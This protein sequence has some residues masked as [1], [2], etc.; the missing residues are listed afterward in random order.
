MVLCVFYGVV[1]IMGWHRDKKLIGLATVERNLKL[2]WPTGYLTGCYHVS[3]ILLICS[4]TMV[5]YWWP[6]IEAT[7]TLIETVAG[8]LP[9]F[10]FFPSRRCCC[11]RLRCWWRRN[12][13][14]V[15][16]C[17]KFHWPEENPKRW[18][19]ANWCTPLQNPKNKTYA[20]FFFF[21]KKIPYPPY[22]LSHEKRKERWIGLC[23]RRCEWTSPWTRRRDGSV[24]DSECGASLA[25]NETVSS[26]RRLLRAAMAVTAVP[27]GALH[28][29][30]FGVFGSADRPDRFPQESHS[31]ESPAWN[32]RRRKRGNGWEM[33]VS[34][35]FEHVVWICS[36]RAIISSSRNS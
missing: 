23:L 6:R 16:H 30:R 14:Y 34:S 5:Q 9:G 7:T 10:Q 25:A 15:L 1:L 17:A 27:L 29:A 33:V 31:I 32:E 8:F 3:L 20:T 4:P 28:C 26:G 2:H 19:P 11:F 22:P 13:N 21:L 36:R 35:S 24:T 18:A 12:A